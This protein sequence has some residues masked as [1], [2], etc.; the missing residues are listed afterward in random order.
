MIYFS[1]G[2]VGT[3][4]DDIYESVKYVEKSAKNQKCHLL[5]KEQGE[6]GDYALLGCQEAREVPPAYCWIGRQLRRE[7]TG[8]AHRLGSTVQGLE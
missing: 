3:E 2:Q 7:M 1:E 5:M 8:L 4:S 6:H